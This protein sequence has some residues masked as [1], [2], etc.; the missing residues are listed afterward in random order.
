MT[1]ENVFLL[2]N[3]VEKFFSDGEDVTFSGKEVAFSEFVDWIV[4]VEQQIEVFACFRKEERF[5][6]V[7]QGFVVNVVN[8]GITA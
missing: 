5:L 2:P 3:L 7:F 6:S 1:V 4:K 8:G